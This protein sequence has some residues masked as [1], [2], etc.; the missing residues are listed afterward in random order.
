MKKKILLTAVFAA[1]LFLLSS[2][3]VSSQT[4]YFCESVDKS[5]YPVSESSVFNISSSGGYLYTLVR[6][7]YEISCREVKLVIYRND[8]Y[9]NTIYIS[10]ERDWTWFW[11]QITFYK[12]GNYTIYAYDCSDYLLTSGNVRIQYK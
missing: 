11:K 5:G 6:L 10:T 9:D 8:N 12:S 3:T 1:V 7:P 4:M 2:N